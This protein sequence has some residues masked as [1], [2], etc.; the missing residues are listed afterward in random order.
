[1][2][3][4]GL[5]VAIVGATG[6]VGEEMRNVLAERNFPVG[7][8]VPLASERSAGQTIEFRGDD[9]EV[10]ALNE[11]S[12]E[13][14]DVALFSAG[15]SISETFAPIAAASGTYVVDN[16]RAFRMVPEVP[17]VVP[18]VNQEALDSPSK[19]I[20]NPNC[21]TI[22]KVVALEPLHRLSTIKRIV[23]STYQS[24]SGAG[25]DGMNELRDQ[26]VDL[27]NFREPKSET[28]TRRLAFD[29]VPQIDVFQD[30]GFTREEHKMI[31]ETRKILSLPTLPV[32]AT[33]VRVPVFVSHAMSINVEF[34]SP[35]SLDA[36]ADAL[37]NAPG[38]IYKDQPEDFPVAADAAGNDDVHVGRLRVDPS[39]ENGLVFWCVSDNLRKG[40]ATNAVQIAEA[41][42]QMGKLGR[43]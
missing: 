9:I 12:F 28:F 34:E 17:L 1:M 35:L 19:I 30:D 14:V 39:T 13:G 4:N 43:S 2:S 31:F 38:V 3:T 10:K 6:A 18:E 25:R 20:A 15:A 41:L 29:T 22:Q 37:R 33:C 16:S 7:T 42:N 5:V 23:V 24:A 8:L 36:A 27:L 32:C 40:A 11:S 21:S 26:T